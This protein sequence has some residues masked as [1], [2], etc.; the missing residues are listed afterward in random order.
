MDIPARWALGLLQGLLPPP[1]QAFITT[2]ILS[3][4]SPVQ[5]VKRQ[6]LAATEAAWSV[7]KPLLVTPVINGATR[8]MYA[9]PDIAVAVFLLGVMLAMVWVLNLVRRA[10]V[11]LT[12]LVLRLAFY[13]GLAA[14]GAVMWQRGFETSMQDALVVGGKLFGW[15]AALKEVFVS[16]YRRYASLENARAGGGVYG[17]VPGGNTNGYGRGW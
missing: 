8:A 10:M 11:S 14:L 17:A 9:S 12:R 15:A 1:A 2:H 16:E 13:S 3:P 7:T 4:S 5:M 6:A